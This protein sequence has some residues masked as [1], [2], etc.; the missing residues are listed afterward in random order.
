MRVLLVPVDPALPVVEANVDDDNRLQ[1]YYSLIGCTTIDIV[2]VERSEFL[3]CTIDLIVDDE[4]LLK[5]DRKLNRRI[6][7]VTGLHLAGNVV[8]CGEVTPAGDES[9]VPPEIVT[10]FRV[11]G[12]MAEPITD[13]EVLS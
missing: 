10:L 1:S 13:E 9:P 4:G 6:L 12:W 2:Q 8:V 11:R 3:P 7:M 5:I